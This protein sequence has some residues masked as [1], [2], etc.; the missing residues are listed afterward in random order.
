VV[1]PT[2]CAIPERHHSRGADA[3]ELAALAGLY[4]D[5]WQCLAVD[6]ILSETEQNRPAAFES[7]IIIARQNGK[8]SILEAL[9]LYWLFIAQEPLI[10]HSAHEFKT[11]AEAF[12]RL[13][14]LIAGSSELSAQVAKITTAAGNEAIE[15]R[16]GERLRYVARSKGSGRGFTAGK[17]ILDEA[18]A[19]TAEEMAA[20]L[21][22]LATRQNAQVVYTSSA[23]MATSTQLHAIRRRGRAGGDASLA[24]LEWGGVAACD[25]FCQHELSDD[26]CALNN[27]QLWV[28][29]NPRV[30]VDFIANERRALPAPEFAR[31]RLTVWDE[32][33][34]KLETIPVGKWLARVDE[35]SKVL[36]GGRPVFSVDVAPDRRSAAIGI[37]GRRDDGARHLGLID[38]RRG[39]DWVVPRVVQLIEDHDP[40]CVVL[41][42]A[43]PAGALLPALTEAGLRR[44]TDT[45]PGAPLVV[46]GAQDMGHACGGL[47][48]AVQATESDVWHRGDPIVTA[49][50]EAAVRRDIGDGLWGLGRKVSGG[51]ITPAVVIALAHWGHVAYG[52]SDYDLLQSFG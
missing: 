16:T 37:C 38:H 35:H 44:R 34:D 51:D 50:W 39:V 21:P 46:T 20:L 25:D 2:W 3:V 18:Y 14:S 5:P 40:V 48:D 27:R 7:A 41:D 32:P 45:D 23:G 42:A 47:L 6:A 9:S 43:S 49:A 1:N 28:D 19:L 22:T 36:T 4:L 33:D 26:A 11:A 24:Y 30:T 12:R 15:L 31:E 8:G 52:E 29:A 10:L 17:I 13:R